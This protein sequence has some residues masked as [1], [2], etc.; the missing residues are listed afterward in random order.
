MVQHVIPSAQKPAAGCGFRPADKVQR[1]APQLF[2]IGAGAAV[3]DRQQTDLPAFVPQL[4]QQAAG[5]GVGVIG[6]GANAQNTQFSFAHNRMLLY[7]LFE[8]RQL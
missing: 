2:P 4:C 8:P 5:A 7:R 3:G 6:M 1:L